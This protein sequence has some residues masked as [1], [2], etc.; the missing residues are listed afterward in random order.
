MYNF[1]GFFLVPIRYYHKI[2]YLSNRRKK[3]NEKKI[4]LVDSRRLSVLSV[5]GD[6]RRRSRADGGVLLLHR[7]RR[8]IYP[9]EY[10]SPQGLRRYV[11]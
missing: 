1:I 3:K 7:C 2:L 9:S 6:L 5:G 8:R 4:P 10:H 11:S